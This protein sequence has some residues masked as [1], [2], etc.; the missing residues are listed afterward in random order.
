MDQ[1]SIFKM[2]RFYAVSELK[3]KMCL[4]YFLDAPPQ[5]L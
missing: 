4:F 2:L 5:Q 1:R 3:H